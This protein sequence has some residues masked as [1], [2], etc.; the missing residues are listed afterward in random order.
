MSDQDTGAVYVFER[1]HPSADQ[2]GQI[3]KL[4]SPNDGHDDMFGVRVAVDDD[5]MVVGA[6][7]DSGPRSTRQSLSGWFLRPVSQSPIRQ[8]PWEPIHAVLI[9]PA[10]QPMS[11][12]LS[13]D[14]AEISVAGWVFLA[15][16]SRGMSCLG[17]RQGWPSSCHCRK[18]SCVIEGQALHRPSNCNLSRPRPSH[19]QDVGLPRDQVVV[20]NAYG[21]HRDGEVQSPRPP[22]HSEI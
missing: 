1:N 21:S 18:S 22:R 7:G 11:S 13:P 9:H 14:R 5:F 6:M 10:E 17:C 3:A 8:W 15:Q 20:E 4:V 2:W 19:G 16:R 12:R